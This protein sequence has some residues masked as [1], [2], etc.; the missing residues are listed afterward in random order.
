MTHARAATSLPLVWM[1][2]LFARY[3]LAD[4]TLLT[5]DP[6]SSLFISELSSAIASAEPLERRGDDIAFEERGAAP[7]APPCGGCDAAAA[8]RLTEIEGIIESRLAK[9]RGFLSPIAWRRPFALS[10]RRCRFTPSGVAIGVRSGGRRGI[11]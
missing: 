6:G 2:R 9:L 5:N 8:A 3:K 1:C 7:G 10:I 4:S 11:T